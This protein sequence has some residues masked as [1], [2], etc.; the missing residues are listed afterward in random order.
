MQVNKDQ[1]PE[2]TTVDLEGY[3]SPEGE[4]LNSEPHTQEFVD[5]WNGVVTPAEST[6]VGYEDVIE[7]AV[8][9]IVTEKSSKA[10]MEIE[11]RKHGIELDRRQSKKS[12]WGKL[13]KVMK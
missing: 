11:A 7:E 13:K 10:E 2:G 4:M 3:Y 5:A 12:L 8:A 9:N 6:M 1:W